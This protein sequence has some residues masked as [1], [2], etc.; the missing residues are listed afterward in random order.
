V[1]ALLLAGA[2]AAEPPAL[3]VG[4]RKQ[5][6]IDYRFIESAE[7][8]SLTVNPPHRTGE[9]LLSAD[10]AWESKLRIGSYSSVAREGG[11]IR[12]WYNVLGKDHEPGKN[13][14]FMGVAYAESRDGIHFEKPILGLVE[15]DG[16]RRNNLVMPAD[17]KLLS[18]G[19]GSVVRD[20][21]PRSPAEERYKSWQKIYPKPGSGIRGQH[22]VW[23]SPDGLHWK[24]S[25]KPVTGLRAADTQPTW[26]WDSRINRY[27]GY[28]REWVSFP[29]GPVR[30]A[31][32]NESDDLH[33]WEKSQ[34]AL[35]PDEADFAAFIRP[36]FEVGSLKVER[37]RLLVPVP[38]RSPDQAVKPGEDPVPFPGA[39]LDMYGPGVFP[40]PEAENVYVGLVPIFHH[41]LRDGRFSWADTGDV[42]LAVSR[43]G[44]HFQHAGPRGPFLRLGPAGSFD[45]KWVWPMPA[46]IRM[47]DEIW[48]Y[49]V[50]TNVAHSSKVEEGASE[51]KTGISRAVM[52]LDGFV[53]ADFDYA[54]GSIIT[55]PIRFTGS[56]LALN[57]DTAGGGV[58]RVEILD[59]AGVPVPGFKLADADHLN[60]NNV[61]LV[62]SWRGKSDVSALA[63]KPVRLHLRMRSA[64]L[65][66]FQFMD[67]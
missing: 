34:I 61:E 65:Y 18:Q 28:S 4:G 51:V 30:M 9:V 50:G 63:G 21:N 62:A 37:D 42:R 45:S 47:G 57:L 49:Y 41:W 48:I 25:P 5:L 31:S 66:A 36:A 20:E 8:M 26:F 43:D 39:P 1:A 32:Y 14:D 2:A 46:P 10:A 6:F 44:M 13:P 53:S 16:S 35:G 56:R 15:V 58:G 52:R 17:P 3:D 59:S 33:S 19:G 64:K 23:H 11:R 54:G 7:G 27:V 55:P 67:R 38:T 29:E 24:L 22:K 12:L 60:G 40:Y